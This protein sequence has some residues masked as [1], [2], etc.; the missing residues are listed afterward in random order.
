MPKYKRRFILNYLTAE[1][2]EK[3]QTFIFFAAYNMVES[4]AKKARFEGT[5]PWDITCILPDDVTEARSG[6]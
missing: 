6:H 3:I 4:A 2:S 5:G 1:T